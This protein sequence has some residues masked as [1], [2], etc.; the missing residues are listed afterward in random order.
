MT[1]SGMQNTDPIL[2]ERSI[3]TVDDNTANGK[4]KLP[5]LISVLV[6]KQKPIIM[7]GIKKNENIIKI[8]IDWR[9]SG[10]APKRNNVNNIGFIFWR[11][12]NSTIVNKS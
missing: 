2:R 7:I 1:P 5:D 10:S 12:F 6:I 3:P 9:I 4:L 8:G 11:I